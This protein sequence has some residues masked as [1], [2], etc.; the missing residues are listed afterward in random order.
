MLATGVRVGGNRL[1]ND[2]LG[3]REKLG[4]EEGSRH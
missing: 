4:M 1:E 2:T 3:V